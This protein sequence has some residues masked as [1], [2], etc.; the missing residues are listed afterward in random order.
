MAAEFHAQKNRDCFPPFHL[1]GLNGIDFAPVP[2]H[3]LP[4]AS[5]LQVRSR[6][7]T[8]SP[9]FTSVSAPRVKPQ[10]C[11]G[12]PS[13][14]C[15]PGNAPRQTRL[16]KEIVVILWVSLSADVM[17]T[18]NKNRI[19]IQCQFCLRAHATPFCSL[20]R[21]GA[22]HSVPSGNLLSAVG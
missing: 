17:Q 12:T 15:M 22:L 3:L 14:P 4:V 1:H 5:E 19:R 10:T 9:L 21:Q 13:A 6:N 8:A 20:R 2:L 18:E 16:G 11:Q 7:S